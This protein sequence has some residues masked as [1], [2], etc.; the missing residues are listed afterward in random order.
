METLQSAINKGY[1]ARCEGFDPDAN[2]YT[3]L[4]AQ[5]MRKAWKAGYDKAWKEEDDYEASCGLPTEDY[6]D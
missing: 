3:A 1:N 4:N 6:E 2:P 5:M